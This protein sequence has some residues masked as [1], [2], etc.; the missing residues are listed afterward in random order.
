MFQIPD[1]PKYTQ[2]ADYLVDNY[3]R[4]NSIFPPKIW[5]AFTADLTRTTNNCEYF[6]SHFNE[7]FYKAHPNI[8]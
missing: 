5:A 1:N 8:F 3:I 7:Q 4:E 6:H 2:Y